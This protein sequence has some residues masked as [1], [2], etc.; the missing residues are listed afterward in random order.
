MS[1]QI[2]KMFEESNRR[3]KAIM[4]GK[5]KAENIAAEQREFEGQI[6]L[7]NAVVSAYAVTSKNAR[8]MK[9]MQKMNLLSSSSAID[10]LANYE[11]EKVCCPEQGDKL[12]T[13]KECLD[14]SG[15]NENI[16]QCQNCENFGIT[17]RLLLP[18]AD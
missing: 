18:K 17:R 5:Y 11:D 8:A 16:D 10:I 4:S 6:K 14:Y 15:D 9:D 13:R 7:L 3:L 2:V 1:S 12:I